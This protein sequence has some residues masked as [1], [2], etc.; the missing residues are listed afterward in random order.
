MHDSRRI[1]I[2]VMNYLRKI[3][4]I[5]SHH[6][7]LCDSYFAVLL[8]RHFYNVFQRYMNTL[9]TQHTNTHQNTFSLEIEF[10][11]ILC[12]RPNSICQLLIALQIGLTWP[13]LDNYWDVYS[14]DKFYILAGQSVNSNHF[15]LFHKVFVLDDLSCD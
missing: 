13:V 1:I 11:G 15:V 2:H 8:E 9:Y 10:F 14:T 12:V 6:I 3:P 4:M 7:H 5:Y